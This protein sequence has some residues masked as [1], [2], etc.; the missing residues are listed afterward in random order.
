MLPQDIIDNTIKANSTSAT[1]PTGYG[2]LGPPSGR[3]IAPI[4]SGGCINEY[5]GSCGL[6]KFHYVFG[7]SFVRFDMSLGKRVDITKRIFAEL[8]VE[9]LNVF[10]NVNFFGTTGTGTTQSS[11]E[12]TSAYRDTSNTQDPGGRLLQLSWRV[13]W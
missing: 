4:N 5:T 12:V 11:Y 1:S 8:R 9:V 13:S 10:D 3:Y 7:P 6:P 2:T